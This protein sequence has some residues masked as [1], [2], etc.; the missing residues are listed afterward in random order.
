MIIFLFYNA[1]IA[2]MF[3]TGLNPNEYAIQVSEWETFSFQQ[4]PEQ[5]NNGAQTEPTGYCFHSSGMNTGI[6]Y[7]VEGHYSGN[8]T[9]EPFFTPDANIPKLRRGVSNASGVESK[10]SL[11]RGVSNASGIESIHT[12]EPHLATRDL[13]ETDPE[14]HH[15]AREGYYQTPIAKDGSTSVTVEEG[16]HHETFN[17]NR[18]DSTN[19]PRADSTK[20][21]SEDSTRRGNADSSSQYD[22]QDNAYGSPPAE[23]NTRLRNLHQR[24]HTLD[25][26][27]LDSYDLETYTIKE[28][29]HGYVRP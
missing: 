11:R 6:D 9:G 15:I 10:K 1:V 13:W 23:A 3:D 19:R 4:D 26:S 21:V 25:V 29:L 8:D 20:E 24:N 27:M 2:N 12:E 28:R 5:I 18:A 16:C 22:R 14:C 7:P 17:R